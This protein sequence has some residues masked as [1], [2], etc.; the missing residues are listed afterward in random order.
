MFCDEEELTTLYG[1]IDEIEGLTRDKKNITRDFADGVMLAEVLH[2]FMP[3]LVELH[4]YRNASSSKA[5]LINWQTINEKVLKKI[6]VD[7]PL[8]VMEAIVGRVQGVVEVVL[9]HIRNAIMKITQP[10]AWNRAQRLKA[11]AEELA[12]QNSLPSEATV[13]EE[14][15]EPEPEP[16]RRPKG[17]R[18][19]KDKGKGEQAKGKKD[20]RLK[21]REGTDTSTTS[22]ED[23]LPDIGGKKKK[24]RRKKKEG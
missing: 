10:K 2:S 19:E 14:P 20:R 22:T 18:P 24:G 15:E 6:G 1:W 3:R 7:I 8:N 11:E 12:Y 5:K 4:N 17:K 16:G 9:I 23:K 13:L 21:K